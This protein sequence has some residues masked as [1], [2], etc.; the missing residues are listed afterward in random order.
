M[1]WPSDEFLIER[2]K[3]RIVR[4]RIFLALLTFGVGGI[5]KPPRSGCVL[6]RL[7][8]RRRG[9]S[10][11]GLGHFGREA[12]HHSELSNSRTLGLIHRVPRSPLARKVLRP[13]SLSR[14][15][16]FS[17]LP[18]QSV[19]DILPTQSVRE[20][21]FL[22][23]SRSFAAKKKTS[24]K[25]NGEHSPLYGRLS[26]VSRFLRVSLSKELHPPAFQGPPNGSAR[27]RRERR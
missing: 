12:T 9:V 4:S 25:P 21:Y 17:I 27:I 3:E 26:L 10:K 5:K 2:Q 22:A 16:F 24:S 8:R 23:H 19:R 15:V 20:P 1:S 11:R 14:M 18:T 13:S 6:D 7:D